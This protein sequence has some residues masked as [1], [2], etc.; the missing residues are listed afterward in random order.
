M[1]GAADEY[2][3]TFLSVTENEGSSTRCLRAWQAVCPIPPSMP[4]ARLL[5]VLEYEREISGSLGTASLTGARE[6]QRG[7]SAEIAA[8]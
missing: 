8:Q 4:S 7:D 1:R 6:N 5:Q 2:R 3:S